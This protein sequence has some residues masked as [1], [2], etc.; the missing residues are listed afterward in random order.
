MSSIS[1]LHFSPIQGA[2]RQ[3]QIGEI[4]PF[5]AAAAREKSS[6]ALLQLPER[7]KANS[8]FMLSISP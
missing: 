1:Q 4:R 5:A 7:T 8:R 2:Q 6:A 3:K